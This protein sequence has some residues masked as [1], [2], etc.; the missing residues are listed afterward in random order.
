MAKLSEVTQAYDE[1]IYLTGVQRSMRLNT[2][3]YQVRLAQGEDPVTVAA[4]SAGNC[5]AY[6]KLLDQ[7]AALDP[8][9]LANGQKALGIESADHASRVQALRDTVLVEQQAQLALGKSVADSL[10]VSVVN[11]LP[12]KPVQT[13]PINGVISADPIVP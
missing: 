8:V 9:A 5:V 2:L 7:R 11:A 1:E 10:A 12:D 3:E 13:L 4:V 6:T